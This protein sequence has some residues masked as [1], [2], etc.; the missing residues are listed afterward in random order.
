MMSLIQASSEAVPTLISAM[1]INWTE[2][3]M[4]NP[5]AWLCWLIPIL[6]ALLMLP[7]AK[8]SPKLRDYAP[9]QHHLASEFSSTLSA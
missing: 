6:G 3:I 5:G 2:V 1:P 9:V 7:I 8:I 4:Q